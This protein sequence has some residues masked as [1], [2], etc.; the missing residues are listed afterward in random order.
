MDKNKLVLS[1]RKNITLLTK[2]MVVAANDFQ[3]NRVAE[4]DQKVTQLLSQLIDKPELRNA[5]KTELD[6]LYQSHQRLLQDCRLGRDAIRESLKYLQKNKE[7]L[8]AYQEMD[9]Q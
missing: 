7:G 1:M 8:L 3:I 9:E 4:L 2:A 5:L 6:A